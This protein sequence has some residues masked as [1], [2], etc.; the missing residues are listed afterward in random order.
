[1]NHKVGIGLSLLSDKIG[2]NSTTELQG[3]YAYH[4]P[5]S[6]QLT[7]SFGLQGGVTNYQRD[8][9]ELTINPDDPG[10]APIS[11]WKPTFG[12]GLILK[13]EKILLSL[14]VP[15]MLNAETHIDSLSTS[16]YTQHFYGLSAYLI[17]LSNRIK[18]KPFVLIRAVKNSPLATDIGLSMRVDDSYA[19]GIFTRN[20]DT[21]GLQAQI[22]VGDLLRFGYVFEL[23]T[24]KSVGLSYT[25]HEIMVGFRIK[26]FL[27]HDLDAIQ[28]F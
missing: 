21:Y 15:K 8:Y 27:F 9:S 3:V 17:Q 18:L 26:A 13:N 14:S 10:F 28:N 2:A 22:N 6:E 20:F 25:S 4:L 24:N 12:S 11:E 7:L 5:L 1:M 16:L 23:P 19:L